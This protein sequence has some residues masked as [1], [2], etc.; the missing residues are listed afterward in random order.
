MPPR[1][2]TVLITGCSDGGL[3]AALALAFHKH[4]D[5]VFATA[6][7]PSKM[8]SL[9]AIGIETLPLDVLSEDSIRSC[10]EKV[11][12]LTDGS[13]D[14]LVNNAGAGLN[15]PVLD[16]SIA[17]IERQF[18]INVFS[19]I[20][21]I[22]LF[23][24]LLRNSTAEH[25]MIVNNSSCGSVLALPFVGPYSASKA[26]LASFSETMRLEMQAFGIKVIDLRTAG[27]RSKFWANV[28]DE[29][30]SSLPEKSPYTPGKDIVEKFL[31]QG[32][33][34]SLMDADVW[35]NKVVR[36]LSKR[37]GKGAPHQIWRGQGAT[38]AWF[39][40]KVLPVGWLDVFVKKLT[41]LDVVEARIKG[42]KEKVV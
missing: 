24:P 10:V 12:S 27:V 15:M 28:N 32:P 5:R 3:G 6:R 34:V 31:A 22:Q 9:Q 17:E 39:G 2:R 33:D 19:A 14:M 23:F 7:I 20:R 25:K 37:G 40:T 18:E 42:E 36:D 30:R 41:G 11:S 38:F 16:V 13:L 1:K 21:M 8:S 26:A 29:M 4:G 35:A